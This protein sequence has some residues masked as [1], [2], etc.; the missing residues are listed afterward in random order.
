MW[1]DLKTDD[2]IVK[3][4]NFNRL[5]HQQQQIQANGRAY[6]RSSIGVGRDRDTNRGARGVEDGRKEERICATRGISVEFA[7]DVEY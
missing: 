3:V 4:M 7:V 1:A 6:S 2:T 5:E